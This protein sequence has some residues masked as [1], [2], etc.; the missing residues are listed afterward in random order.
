MLAVFLLGVPGDAFADDYTDCRSASNRATRRSACKRIEDRCAPYVDSNFTVSECTKVIDFL[1]TISSADRSDFPIIMEGLYSTRARAYRDLEQWDKVIADYNRA[2]TDPSDKLFFDPSDFLERAKAYA[3]IGNYKRAIADIDILVEFFEARF[4]KD[5]QGKS[6]LVALAIV[7]NER[8]KYL[9]MTRSYNSALADFS[10]VLQLCNRPGAECEEYKRDATAGRGATYAALGDYDKAV[11]DWKAVGLVPPTREQFKAGV[12][13]AS[14]FAWIKP[15]TGAPTDNSF[16]FGLDLEAPATADKIISAC[17]RRIQLAPRN[18]FEDYWQRGKAYLEIGDYDRSIADFDAIISSPAAHSSSEVPTLWIYL[19]RQDRAAAFLA[20]GDVNRAISELNSIVDFLAKPPYTTA[21][22]FLIAY[23]YGQRA[24]A[25]RAAKQYAAAVR[26]SDQALAW[27]AKPYKDLFD[28]KC[29][30][31]PLPWRKMGC[32]GG[33][34]DLAI[35]DWIKQGRAEAQAALNPQPAAAPAPAPAAAAAPPAPA[36]PADC[37]A[38]AAHWKAAESLD[39]IEAYQDHVTRFPNCPFASLARLK[40]DQ[41]KAG[42]VG[43][44]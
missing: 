42:A 37:S 44:R 30:R 16:C 7:R 6:L 14:Q 5:Q 9:L 12:R 19:V 23:V 40:I 4:A 1:W 20:K 28:L 18:S 21:S 27:M 35:M 26:D 11:V 24:E 36:A 33:V 43:K 39:V 13:T 31:P 10:R 15:N 34:V 17:S 8:G 29:H 38:A 25:L 22:P 32:L 41:L 3:K 2:H